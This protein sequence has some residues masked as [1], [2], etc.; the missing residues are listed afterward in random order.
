[1]YVCIMP[2]FVCLFVCWEMT[3]SWGGMAGIEGA[4]TSSAAQRGAQHSTAQHSTVQYSTGIVVDPF[5]RDRGKTKLAIPTAPRRIGSDR[6]HRI[7]MHAR[8]SEEK[9]LSR[10]I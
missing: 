6:I 4:V 9:K 8:Y 2:K 1:M 10:H 7:A 5:P 3:S